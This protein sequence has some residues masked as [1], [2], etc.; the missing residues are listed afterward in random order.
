MPYITQEAAERRE[1]LFV[2]GNYYNT[3]DGTC[4]R[5]YLHVMD[6]AE[7]H[8]KALNN[9]SSGIK[10]YN[11]GYGTPHSVLEVI[12]AFEKMNSV[13]VN[14]EFAD[15][16]KGDI[17]EFWSDNTKAKKELNWSPKRNLE[18]MVIDAWNWEKNLNDS[19]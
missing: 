15:R 12:E 11:L 4:R 19:L 16:R 6:V 7:G 10:I 18:N 1:K 13:K 5:D 8:V 14:Y 9:I 3:P 2:Y 17:D